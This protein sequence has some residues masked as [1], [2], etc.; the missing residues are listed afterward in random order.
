MTDKETIIAL[1][2]ISDASIKCTGC[3]FNGIKYYYPTCAKI[4]ASH[5]VKLID[6][7]RNES[8][9]LTTEL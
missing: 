6:K 8:K 4:V 7:L 1:R 3:V 2:C 5:A 9:D